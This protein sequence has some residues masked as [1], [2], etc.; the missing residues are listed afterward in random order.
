MVD[1]ESL[2]TGSNAVVTQIGACAFDIKT[3]ENDTHGVCLNLRIQEQLDKG[4]VITGKTLK[5]WLGEIKEAKGECTWIGN[6]LAP[7]SAIQALQQYVSMYCSKGFNMW[8]HTF[9]QLILNNLSYMYNHKLPWTYRQ[10]RDIRTLTCL[11]GMKKKKSDMV[12]QKTHNG[13]DD[14]LCQIEYCCEAWQKVQRPHCQ[15]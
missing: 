6:E 9:D 5:W 3:G 14:C 2:A 8:S 10:S 11:A 15:C 1:L 13:L 12:H 4:R 7:V